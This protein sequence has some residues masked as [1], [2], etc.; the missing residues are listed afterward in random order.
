LWSR[1]LL[2][3]CKAGSVR[4]SRCSS[5]AVALRRCWRLPSVTRTHTHLSIF[6]H[7]SPAWT[8]WICFVSSL[9]LGLS[10]STSCSPSC[11]QHNKAAQ[12]ASSPPIHTR[13]A[14]AYLCLHFRSPPPQHDNVA[15][16]HQYSTPAIA[17]LS[18]FTPIVYPTTLYLSWYT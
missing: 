16:F 13:R 15:N 5:V 12:S 9:Q 1:Q 10:N 18:A 4:L 3:A 7:S 6:S 17:V 11:A 2:R 8:A 14:V